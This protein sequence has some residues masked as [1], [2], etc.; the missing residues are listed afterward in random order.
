MKKI[1]IVIASLL[2]FN[3]QTNAQKVLDTSYMECSYKYILMRD[4]VEKIKSTRDADMRL[5]VGNK[6][7]KF[8][9]RTFFSLD[10]LLK[11]MT[12][13]EQISMLRGGDLTN[14]IQKYPSGEAYKVYKNY[15][16]NK[17]IFTDRQPP[18]TVLCREPMLKQDWKIWNETNEI[19]GYKCQKATCTFRGRD[20]I[21]WFT[22]EIPIPEGP[23]KFNGLPGLI[24]K[25]YDTKEH[26]DFE[27]VFLQKTRKEITFEEERYQEVSI[28][29]YIKICRHRIQHPL[30][31]LKA[32]VRNF[33]TT[34]SSEPKQYYVMERNI[35]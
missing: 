4:T 10:S 6:Y 12:E 28:K 1:I 5:L 29:D 16:D 27:L 31:N 8:Y 24:V 23:C 32:R 25:I 21:A 9:S 7:S 19:A 35:E 17:I 11:A 33:H 13:A 3:I 14:L 18:S 26:Y 34:A 30:E 20:Y 15:V 2:F 22:R